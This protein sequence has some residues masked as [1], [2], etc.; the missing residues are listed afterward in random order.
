MTLLVGLSGPSISGLV[1]D[2]RITSQGVLVDD[3]FNKTTVLFCDDAKLAIAFTG[4]ATWADFDTQKWLTGTLSSIGKSH[5]HIADIL[6]EFTRMAT[7]RF[8]TLSAPDRRLAVMFVGYV[9]W[10][11]IPSNVIY[12]VSNFGATDNSF[13]RTSTNTGEAIVEVAGCERAVSSKDTGLLE[14]ALRLAPS[15]A[16]I[17]QKAVRLV[18]NV[19]TTTRSAG[20]VG[21]QCNSISM[22]AARDTMVSATYHSAHKTGHAYGCSVVIATSTGQMCVESVEIMGGSVLAGP[23]IGKNN[24]CWCGS[25]KKFKHCHLKLLGAV[26]ANTPFF[27]RPLPWT[28]QQKSEVSVASGRAFTVSS[29]FE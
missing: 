17:I 11:K 24:C 13:S 16:A 5:H 9:Y 22:F 10:E 27:R 7:E 18:Q 21:K 25:G 1:A 26:Y 14:Q 4:L 28:V 3:E 20:L 23:K 6:E 29:S 2:R 12:V 19:A 8:M 15:K